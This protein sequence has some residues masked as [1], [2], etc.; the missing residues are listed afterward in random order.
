VDD[1]ARRRVA[2]ARVGHLATV[3]PEGRPHLVPFTFALQ[4]DVVY[5]AVDA[6]PKTT[7]ALK[8]LDNIRAHP[9]VAV[10]VDDYD[11]DWSR[12]WWVRLDGEARILETGPERGRAIDLLTAK[13][14]Q[15]RDRPPAGP[16]I[17]VDVGNWRAWEA[18]P[19][20]R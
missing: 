2:E 19:G 11:E 7:V 3:G 18:S 20:V 4:G 17:A 10:L 8:R 16:V 12:L 14:P 6:K 15:Y 9:G 5:S 13:Y 1:G